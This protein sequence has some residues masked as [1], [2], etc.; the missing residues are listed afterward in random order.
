[1]SSRTTLLCL[2]FSLSVSF[3]LQSST[4]SYSSTVPQHSLVSVDGSQ[5]TYL[6]AREKSSL[7]F[8]TPLLAY[9]TT[10]STIPYSTSS[11][12][13]T[14]SPTAL[15]KA[16]DNNDPTRLHPRQEIWREQV[17][18]HST[19]QACQPI[20]LSAG[21]IVVGSTTIKISEMA[22]GTPS[23]QFQPLCINGRPVLG[24]VP[25]LPDNLAFKD[26]IVSDH[27][28]AWTNWVATT[29]GKFQTSIVPIMYSMAASAVTCWVLTLVVLGFQHKRTL[30][31]K[32]AL[33]CSSIYLLIIMI[34]SSTIL[35]TQYRHGYLDS[36]ELRHTLRSNRNINILNLTFNTLLYF[37]QVQ[38]AMY[39][40]SRQMEKRIVFWL[41]GSLTII[42]QTIWGISVLHPVLSLNSLP[43]FSYLFQIALSIL[44]LCC[45]A[46][47]AITNHVY[48]LHPSLLLVTLLA[49]LAA[50]STMILFIVDLANIWVMEWADS[51]SWITTVFSIVM[52]REWADR[53][54]TMQ[55]QYEKTSVLGRQ[56]FEDEVVESFSKND[57]LLATSTHDD[58]NVFTFN[59]NH[60]ANRINANNS[61]NDKFISKQS[62]ATQT[63]SRSPA[64]LSGTTATPATS[65]ET[66]SPTRA[67]TTPGIKMHHAVLDLNFDNTAEDRA[68]SARHLFQKITYPII[69]F[70]D[71]VINIGLSVSRPLSSVSNPLTPV[72]QSNTVAANAAAADNSAINSGNLE[73]TATEQQ[74]I[75]DGKD[76]ELQPLEKFYY[77][78]RKK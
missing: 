12:V 48:T 16:S 67:R 53:V 2:F 58:F 61:H 6:T 40:F 34:K 32:L 26:S 70:S 22:D 74:F 73:S 57:P 13:I 72:D 55:R 64:E 69:Y 54:Y 75:T 59:H 42:A 1:M 4:L 71:L 43:A 50:S 35:A 41:G 38:T 39:L 21:T 28:Q 37:G 25:R 78:Q 15:P 14:L 33:L 23:I 45:A 24:T 68:R 20:H 29:E 63:I 5:H 31:Y 18:S 27:S 65:T 10:L 49:L 9:P 62:N 17:T 11:P 76:E 60:D 3:S 36:M 30:L 7:N 56:L 51:L 8:P 46:Y 77:P 66:Q 52:V 19:I 44:Y 47:F